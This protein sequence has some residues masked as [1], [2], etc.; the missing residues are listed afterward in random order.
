[1]AHAFGRR[2]VAPGRRSRRWLAGGLA[3]TAWL[4]V[5]VLGFDV[6]P[7]LARTCD[8]VTINEGIVSPGS[9][10]TATSFAFSVTFVDTTGTAPQSIRLRIAESWKTLQPS[11]SDYATGVKFKGSRKLPVGTW[12]YFFRATYG[13][14]LICDHVRVTPLTVIVAPEPTPKPTATPKPTPKPTPRA[15]PRPTPRPTPRAT[16]KPAPKATPKPAAPAT[17][18]PSSPSP[19][20]GAQTSAAPSSTP[21]S[22]AAVGAVGSIPG[23]GDGAE[24][25]GGGGGLGFDVGRLIGGSSL[26]APLIAAVSAIVAGLLFLFGRRRSRRDRSP[27]EGLAVDAT[28]MALEAATLGP[29][30]VLQPAAIFRQ[31]LFDPAE[32]MPAWARPRPA[33]APDPASSAGQMVDETAVADAA[34]TDDSKP[35]KRTRRPKANGSSGASRTRSRPAAKPDHDT[36]DG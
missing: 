13:G 12:G 17:P 8:T 27:G 24:N 32:I 3:L 1:M 21:S 10:T 26:A 7:A 4:V 6:D 35:T 20:P 22:I 14:G 9:G 34:P 31:V 5:S 16:P 18:G 19:K 28:A 25:T 2:A 11:G 29:P 30:P 36:T 33:P 23:R 15:T